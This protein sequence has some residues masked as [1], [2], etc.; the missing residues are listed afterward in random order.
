LAVRPIQDHNEDINPFLLHYLDAY[1]D[2][3][4]PRLTKLRLSTR[5]QLID[6]EKSVED[7]NLTAYLFRL[8]ARPWLRTQMNYEYNYETDDG[9]SLK[10]ELRIQRLQF[11]WAFRQLSLAANAYYTQEK[12]GFTERDRWS[13]RLTLLRSF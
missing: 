3:Q 12:Q 10:R 4:L 11:R 1:I 5:R 2:F 9:G 6:N 13:I 8:Q 7:V